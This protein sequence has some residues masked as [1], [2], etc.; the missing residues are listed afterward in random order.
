MPPFDVVV[1]S[2]ATWADVKRHERFTA[3]IDVP[4]AARTVGL[5][6]LAD[7]FSV[8]ALRPGAFIAIRNKTQQ[9]AGKRA[10]IALE[11]GKRSASRLVKDGQI[12]QA[13]AAKLQRSMYNLT[14]NTVR[15]GCMLSVGNARLAEGQQLSTDQIMEGQQ[16]NTDTLLEGQR[17]LD[18]KL[19][20]LLLNGNAS[21][22]APSTSALAV[23]GGTLP[24]DLTSR[25]QRDYAAKVTA[26]GHAYQ[27]QAKERAQDEKAE[28]K[29]KR[30][31]LK[32]A[33]EAAA[34]KVAKD[35]ADIEA[36][37][38]SAYFE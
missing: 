5:D 1:P 16:A 15:L 23:I 25:E 7:G 17:A 18:K 29:R 19:D 27:R 10:L 6:N 38:V 34:A 8:C 21:G 35:T 33:K 13:P 37:C 14:R 4:V 30:E 32:E 12:L 31:E 22:A 9:P 36:L 24:T 11:N 20:R 26:Q 2:N 3:K 28:C